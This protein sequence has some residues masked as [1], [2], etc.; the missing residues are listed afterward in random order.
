MEI[1]RSLGITSFTDYSSDLFDL[2]LYFAFIA[3]WH[4]TAIYIYNYLIM[5][6]SHEQACSWISIMIDR[7]HQC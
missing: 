2:S 1:S 6:V 5:G 4:Y 7:S 3:K